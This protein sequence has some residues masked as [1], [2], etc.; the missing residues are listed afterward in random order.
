MIVLK[1]MYFMKSSNL[2][3][4]EWTSLVINA[5][6]TDKCLSAIYD[7]SDNRP[8]ISINNFIVEWFLKKFGTRE[9]SE[10]FLKD[11]LF[12]IKKYGIFHERFKLFCSFSDLENLIE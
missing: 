9:I 4:K 5:M 6:I 8:N 11:F 7:E 2:Q 10:L 12:S 1:P 3:T